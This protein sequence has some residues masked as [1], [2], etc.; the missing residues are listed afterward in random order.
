MTGTKPVIRIGPQEFTLSRMTE[1]D[2]LEVVEIEEQSGLSRWGWNAYHTE[3]SEG[4]GALMFVARL[5][6]TEE[7][8]AAGQV[9]G[10]VASRLN[11]DE[12]HINNIAVRH[13]YRR[14]GLGG[15][16]L[17]AVLREG[18]RQGARKA[19]LEVRLSNEAAQKLYTK[20]GFKVMA[21]R[22]NYY[23]QPLE[24]ALLMSASLE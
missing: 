14:C 13:V 1:H 8:N 16:L 20:Y 24:D 15:A 23:T 17:D 2:L 10:F 19:L 9:G 7:T 6:G 12:L 3:L 22:P 21:R 5:Q 11:A 18:A 4:L